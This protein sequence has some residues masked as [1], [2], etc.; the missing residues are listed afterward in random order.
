VVRAQQVFDE[1]APKTYN[2]D[3]QLLT[4]ERW[5]LEPPTRGLVVEFHTRR[6]GW[7]TYTRSPSEI[8]DISLFDRPGRRVICQ[9][10]S[11]T[12]TGVRPADFDDNDA[13]AFDVEHYFDGSDV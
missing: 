2:L 3:L 5:S 11:A 10:S 13:S 4:N 6:H 9:Y 7:L 8:E 12:E 1:Y